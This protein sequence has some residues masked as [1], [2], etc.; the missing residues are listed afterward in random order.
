LPGEARAVLN[1]TSEPAAM[2][3]IVPTAKG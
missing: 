1:A 3:V 2:I